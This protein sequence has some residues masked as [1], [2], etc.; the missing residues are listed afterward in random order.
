MTYRHKLV[1]QP[2][3]LGA[4]EERHRWREVD[5]G[6]RVATVGDEGNAPARDVLPADQ[7]DAKDRADGRPERLRR[8]RVGAA[9]REGDAGAERVGGPDQGADV[10]RVSEAPEAEAG[11]ADGGREV[12]AAVDADR[13]SGMRQRRDAGEQGL[14]DR[15]AGDEEVDGLDP[16]GRGRLD[17]VFPSTANSPLSSRCFRCPR[18]LRTSLACRCRAR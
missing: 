6:Q 1:R 7:R 9:V 2:R 3:A 11:V 5:V 12:G 8:E 17:E 14:V 16:R 18:S 15:L 10:P 13:A 4:E